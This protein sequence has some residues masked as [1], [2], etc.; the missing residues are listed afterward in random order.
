[1]TKERDSAIKEP[2]FSGDHSGILSP[3]RIILPKFKKQIEKQRRKQQDEISDFLQHEIKNFLSSIRESKNHNK[4]KQESSLV[5]KEQRQISD[6][7][8]TEYVEN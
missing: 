2:V 4:S 6:I 3:T 5:A 1:M 7:S 8:V